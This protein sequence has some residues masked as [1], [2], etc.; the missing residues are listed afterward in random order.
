MNYFRTENLSDCLIRIYGVC[1]EQMYLIIGKEKAALIDTGCGVGDLRQEADKLTD[2]PVTV[3]LTHGHVDHAFGANGFPVI[4]MSDKDNEI[5]KSHS[6]EENSRLF[7]SANPD[8]SEEWFEHK[9]PVPVL[10]DFKNLEDGDEFDLGGIHI[11]VYECPGHT[12]GSMC[13]LLREWKI[14]ITGDACNPATFLFFPETCTVLE[15]RDNLTVLEKRTQGKYDRILFSHGT[16]E[17]TADII[18]NVIDVCNDILDGNFGSQPLESM[19][20]KGIIA[21]EIDVRGNRKD[22][23]EGNI[24]F[25]PDRIR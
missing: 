5:F 24:V 2:K 15:Y 16:G 7:F 8:F 19:S 11:D 13:F 23:I 4:Y 22:G 3:L 12:Q 14:L 21:K 6:L 1:G 17:S 10:K 18:S 9:A 25:N 20:Y